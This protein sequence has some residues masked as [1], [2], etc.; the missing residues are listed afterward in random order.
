MP[1]RQPRGPS[2][3]H[4]GDDRLSIL[5][6]RMREARCKAIPG[7]GCGSRQAYLYCHLD[8][9]LDD[10]RKLSGSALSFATKKQ[11]QRAMLHPLHPN[12]C[13]ERAERNSMI[14]KEKKWSG[15]VDF[16]PTTS[17]SPTRKSSRFSCAVNCW[18]YV[19][20][21]L[22]FTERSGDMVY[23]SGLD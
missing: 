20:S 7:H 13:W 15:R 2:R 17:W 22:P 4:R 14:C 8:R 10:S 11:S 9:F 12:Q 3:T 6:N 23:T 21:D 16:E 5:H 18:F 1:W 19:R